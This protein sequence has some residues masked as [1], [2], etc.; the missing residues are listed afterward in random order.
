MAFDLDDQELEYTRKFLKNNPFKKQ[1]QIV[2]CGSRRFK[3]TI[4]KIQEHLSRLGYRVLIP[5]ELKSNIN[6]KN[7]TRIHF[8]K[9]ADPKTDIVLVIN[10]NIE[11]TDIENYIGP[12]TFAEIAFAFYKN[13]D[14]YLLNDLYNY[15]EEEL[16]AWNVKCCKGDLNKLD[17]GGN[18]ENN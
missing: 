1:K 12:N 15:C 18:N 10:E 14:I 16:E 5:E 3:S 2:L 11:D 4:L 17:I 8:D 7:A 13:K 6:K 9:I